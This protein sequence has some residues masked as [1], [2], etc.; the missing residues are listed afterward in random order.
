MTNLGPQDDSALNSSIRVASCLA[1]S[2]THARL[3][4]CTTS[5]MPDF[6]KIIDASVDCL[7]GRHHGL[8]PAATQEL[9]RRSPDAH[10]GACSGAEQLQQAVN[11]GA[12]GVCML[13]RQ[14]CHCPSLVIGVGMSHWASMGTAAECRTLIVSC[15]R[16]RPRRAEE[17]KCRG[18]SGRASVAMQSRLTAC[19]KCDVASVP[20]S[21]SPV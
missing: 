1:A 20:V 11:A 18:S 17:Q 21:S 16:D 7:A 19:S 5:T 2:S 9:Q 3:P 6:Q 13:H 10:E 8:F 12:P 14:S 15:S 4:L